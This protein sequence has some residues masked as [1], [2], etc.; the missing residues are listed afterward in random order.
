[1]CSPQHLIPTQGGPRS[2]GTGGRGG[3]ASPLPRDAWRSVVFGAVL[4]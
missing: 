2:R 4:D 1:M 3:A